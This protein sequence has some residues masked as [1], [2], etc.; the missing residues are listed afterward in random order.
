MR[1]KSLTVNAGFR[2]A[3]TCTACPGDF[4]TALA[5]FPARLRADAAVLRRRHAEAVADVL[6]DVACEL[7]LALRDHGSEALRLGEA[8]AEC[9]LSAERLRHLVAA[10]TLPN[11][12]RRGSPRIR[13]SDLV[14]LSKR[15]RHAPVTAA[16]PT[17]AGGQ[18]R[19]AGGGSR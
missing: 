3:H 17:A 18:L 5:D 11:A 7:E 2:L 8:S 16:P 19:G 12:G 6:I 14:G 4:L 10:G 1:R 13:R 9:G 15:R